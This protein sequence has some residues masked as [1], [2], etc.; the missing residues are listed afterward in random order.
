MLC[1][2]KSNQFIQPLTLQNQDLFI[3][4]MTLTWYNS[5][6]C[7]FLLALE[8]GTRNARNSALNRLVEFFSIDETLKRKTFDVTPLGHG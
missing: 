1:W 7:S 8:F 3:Y 4:L 2:G 6:R 5:M